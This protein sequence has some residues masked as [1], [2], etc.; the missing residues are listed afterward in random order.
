MLKRFQFKR[1]NDGFSPLHL[2]F[3]WDCVAALTRI[4]IRILWGLRV[5]GLHHVPA[6][7]PFL[8]VANHQSHFDPMVLGSIMAD[9]APRS[10]A[11]RSLIEGNGPAGWLI[12][13]AYGSIPVDRGKDDP[14]GM[15]AM[16]AEMKAGRGILI[17]PEGQRFNDGTVHKFKRGVWL[18]IKRGKVP[19][20]PVGISGS[21]AAWPPGAS[22]P[23]LGPKIT[24]TF[25]EPIDP[26]VLLDA[27][28]V[29]AL[30][31]LH[32][33]VSALVE[34]SAAR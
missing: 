15:R 23:V 2:L 7:G 31:M 25:G 1:R 33:K 24:V 32:A 4:T 20:I 30:G 26:T 22:R 27:G 16:F 18:L 34:Q 6:Q 9:R 14:G 28:E 17:Y 29:D 3:W 19:V 21:G 10:L 13:R 12:G 11:R 8:V 5:R